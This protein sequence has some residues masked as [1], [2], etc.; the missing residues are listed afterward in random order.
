LDNYSPD[1]SVPAVVNDNAGGAYTATRHLAALGHTRIGFVG[2]AVDYP[3]GRETH[4][5]YTRALRDAGIPVDPALEM[6]VPIDSEAAQRHAVAFFSLP[7][8]PT[9]IFAVTDM[10]ALGVMKAAREH[11]RRIPADLSVAGMDDIDLA[12]VTDPG[13][14]TIRIRKEEMGRKAAEVLLDLIQGKVVDQKIFTFSNELVVRG[15]TG[16]RR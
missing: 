1:L 10:L 4:E 15:T 8:P 13:L 2:A 3:F 16:E 9:A 14:T 12:V 11:G 7:E 6:R 5:G